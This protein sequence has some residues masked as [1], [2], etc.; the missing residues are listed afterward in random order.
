MSPG[1][2]MITIS[3]KHMTVNNNDAII[4]KNDSKQ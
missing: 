2:M 4:L 1:I 3:I